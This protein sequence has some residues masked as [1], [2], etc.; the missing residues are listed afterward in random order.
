MGM[1]IVTNWQPRDLIAWNDL[2]EKARA[3]FDY[4]SDESEQWQPRFAC[5]RGQWVDCLDTQRIE[6]DNG[7]AH[8]MGWAM[9]VHPGSP[10]CHFD[11]VITDSYFSGMLFRFV[12]NWERVIIGRF[13]S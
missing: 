1:E 11:S 6:P 8:P 13:Y 7:R 12:D 2:P 9:R 4:V 10:L 5:Y 3:E